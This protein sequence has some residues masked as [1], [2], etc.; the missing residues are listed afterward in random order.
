MVLEMSDEELDGV[1]VVCGFDEEEG[2][3]MGVTTRPVWVG[4]G[5]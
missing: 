5:L 2:E 1:G 3:L 4:V